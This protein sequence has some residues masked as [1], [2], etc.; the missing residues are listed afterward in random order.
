MDFRCEGK[1]LKEVM[2]EDIMDSLRL[3]FPENFE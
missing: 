1:S 2:I 3:E